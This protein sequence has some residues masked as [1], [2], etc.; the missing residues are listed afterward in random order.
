[1]ENSHT[2][3]QDGG[4]AYCMGVTRWS[5]TPGD[6]DPSDTPGLLQSYLFIRNNVS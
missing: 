2:T 4:D 3:F 1:M 5:A 6:Q